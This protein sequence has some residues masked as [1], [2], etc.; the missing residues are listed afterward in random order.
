MTNGNSYRYIHQGYFKA[1]ETLGYETYWL[2]NF[3]TVNPSFFENS[4]ILTEGWENDNL[5]ICKNSFYFIHH[6]GDKTKNKRFNHNIKYVCNDNR[7]FDL[8]FYCQT[9]EDCNQKWSVSFDSLQRINYCA[10]LESLDGY[11]ALYQPWATDLLP[12]EIDFDSIN[13]YSENVIYFVGTVGKITEDEPFW[14]RKMDSWDKLMRFK[15]ACDE[16]NIPFRIIDYTHE[17]NR[18]SCE[19]YIS[20]YKKS[21]LCPD[22]R[23]QHKLEVGYIPCR[24]FKSI[25][26]GRLGMTDSETVHKFFNQLTAYHYDPYHL[27][28]EGMKYKDDIHKIRE[29]MK[30]VKDHHTYIN[31]IKTLETC[32]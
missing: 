23:N 9:F 13:K 4:I 12:N 32:L 6:F 7:V 15:Q 11:K 27:F 19:D 28:Y 24:V 30:L 8:R 31:R 3:D 16:N 14:G 18:L 2:D 21:L 17:K 5:P 26:Y 22:I 10:C 20:T 1:A 29:S 25:S